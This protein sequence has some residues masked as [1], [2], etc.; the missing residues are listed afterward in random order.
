MLHELLLCLWF[1]NLKSLILPSKHKA[2]TSTHMTSCFFL[3]HR[4]LHCAQMSIVSFPLQECLTLH[5]FCLLLVLWSSSI[6]GNFTDW[7]SCLLQEASK[8]AKVCY[9][10][11]V[12]VFFGSTFSVQLT[13]LYR[14]Q[15]FTASLMVQVGQPAIQEGRQ[16][17]VVLH[18]SPN[19]NW[20]I[21]Y[22]YIYSSYLEWQG[23]SNQIYNTNFISKINSFQI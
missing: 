9:I 11:Q 3:S 19:K 20:P 21:S 4:L 7:L 22:I 18:R 14:T 17:F 1:F 5:F 8:G 2:I 10:V 15:T 16:N 23:S 6:W 13:S 12:W